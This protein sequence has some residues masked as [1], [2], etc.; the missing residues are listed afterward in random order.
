LAG[1]IGEPN[2]LRR[3]IDHDPS[4]PSPKDWLVRNAKRVCA[5][6][7]TIAVIIAGLDLMNVPVVQA[8]AEFIDAN[9][10]RFAELPN[11]MQS[12]PTH[13]SGDLAASAIALV[14]AK[15]A[16]PAEARRSAPM[17][18]ASLGPDAVQAARPIP[19]VRLPSPA[20]RLHLKGPSLLKSQHCLARAI[21]FEARGEPERGQI[22]VAQVVL[23][24]VFSGYYPSNVCDVVYQNSDRYLSC[25]FTFACDGKSDVINE[26]GAWARANRIAAQTLAGEVY[27]TAV[28]ASTHYHAIYVHP[29][30][31]GEMHKLV[32][33]GIHNF[34]RPIAWGSGADEP[35][36][37]EAAAEK[38]KKK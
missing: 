16:A 35:V 30:W 6:M 31:V 11:Q 4:A 24:R 33:Y 2:L 7:A 28:G 9:Q 18:L 21:Y 19:D 3:S 34:Y 13:V 29:A 15:P 25:Q 37:G 38:E 23:N 1:D 22:A 27:D 8:A 5:G 20:E 12:D 17:Q 32:R 26:R 36:W 10:Q 14:P